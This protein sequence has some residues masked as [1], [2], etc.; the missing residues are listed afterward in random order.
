MLYSFSLSGTWSFA[1]DPENRGTRD[2]W[3]DAPLEDHIEL[4]GSI[5]EAKLTPE[6]HSRTMAHLSRRHPYVGRAWYARDITVEADAAGLFFTLVLERPHG[7]VNVYLDGFKIGRDRSL[8]TEHR[9]FLGTLAAGPHRLVLMIDNSRFEAV[10]EAIQYM[11][12]EFYDVAHANTDH[13]QTN[14]NGVVGAL[15]IEAARGAIARMDID[16]RSRNVAVSFEL[17]AYDSDRV[18]PTF[19]DGKA[20]DRLRLTISLAG[21]DTPVLVEQPLDV[22]SAFTPLRIEV[23]LPE[24]AGL[25]DE[26]DPVLHSLCAEWIR[27]GEIIDRRESDF[28]IRSFRTEGRHLLLNERRVFLRG[29]LDC[30]VFPL[31]GYPPTDRAGWRKVFETVKAYGLN[32]VRFHS[33][34]PPNAAFEVAD[35]LGVMLAVEG[36]VWPRLHADPNLDDFIWLE[37]ARIFRDYGNHP[38]FVMFAIGNELHGDGLH[39]FASKFVRYWREHDPRRLYTGGSGWPTTPEADYDSKPEPRC[40]AWGDGLE[41]RLNA[42]PLETE[43]DWSRDRDAT[44]HPLLTHEAGQ[45]CAYPNVREIGKYTGVLA[46]RNLEMVRDDLEAKGRLGEADEMLMASGALQTLLYKEELEAALRTS[47]F[48]GTQ[49]LGLQDFPG[50]G[51][52]LVGVVDAFWDAKPYVTAERFR[53]FCAQVVPL[54]RAPRF[55]VEQ[56]DVFTARIQLAHFGPPE[57]DI[58]RLAFM[59][60]DADGT[61][62]MSGTVG[63]AL[64]KSGALNDVGVLD[65]DT[66]DLP[67]S[68]RYE[69]VI[70]VPGTAFRNRWS[71]WVFDKQDSPVFPVTFVLDE[72]VIDR[73]QHG[74]TI[75]FMPSPEMIRPNS[76]LGFTTIFWNT[77]WTSGQAP[78][79][80]GLINAIDHAIFSVFPSGRYSDFHWWELVHGRR[81]FDLAGLAAHHI[82]QVVDDWNTNRD[83]AL[84]AELG[85]GRGRLLLCGFDLQNALSDR[86]VARCMHRAL[87]AYAAS[88]DRTPG[89]P[90][91]EPETVLAWWARQRNDASEALR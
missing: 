16:A 25:W 57:I 80:L 27:N 90:V 36:P 84:L 3:F 63:D 28:G 11:G 37:S 62:Y 29:T 78:H 31:T 6:T 12:P 60:R 89:V 15:R 24:S 44:D 21:H 22:V 17:E 52:A 51:T 33:Y 5:D 54:L 88:A 66:S 9:F 8:S 47:D 64:L 85:I 71:F 49:L 39:A 72:A 45:W 87:A 81:A 41:G 70:F 59:V 2:A 35:R 46:A 76:T 23:A 74:E 68:A 61:Q 86:P 43:T 4:P 75:V 14:W 19:W 26:F 56:G 83:L 77:L 1:L 55:I 58:S 42:G 67:A 48:A 18:H 10:G 73:V 34:C 40:Q 53:E 69:I 50:Q 30:C 13:T 91:V 79:T 38:S 82:V 65:V 32:H 20:D 7:E